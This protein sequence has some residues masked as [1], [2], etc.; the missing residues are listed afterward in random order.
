MQPGTLLDEK[1]EVAAKPDMPSQIVGQSTIIPGRARGTADCNGKTYECSLG[2]MYIC[3]G[4]NIGGP[5][6]NAMTVK[7][8]EARR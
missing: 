3:R 6:V 2:L 5:G 7:C 4:P 8:N 1:G